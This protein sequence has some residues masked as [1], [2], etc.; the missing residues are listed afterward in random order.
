[1]KSTNEGEAIAHNQGGA[2]AFMLN[3]P[4]SR[5]LPKFAIP[6]VISLVIS[7]LYNIVDQIFVG[8]GIGYLGN[9]A[10][11]II[12]PITVVGWGL[13]LLFGDGGAAFFSISQGAGDTR[14]AGK[15]VGNSVLFSFLTGVALIVIC[16]AAGDSF[17]YALGATD[18]T[19]QFVRD[20]GYIIFAGIPLALAGQTLITI[21]RADGSPKYAMFT[22]LVGCI[23]NI[24][25]D[26]ITIFIWGWGIK[27]A[28]WATIFG[29]AV[30]FIL[31]I[32]YL[33]R[34][35]TFKIKFSDF[36]PDWG[37][38]RQ[39][40]PLGGSSFLT[41]ISIVIVT[42]VNNKLLVSYGAKSEFGADIPLAAFVVIMK[43]FQIVLNIAIGIAA[44]AQPIIG[45]NYGARR[46]DRVKETFKYVITSILAVTLIATALFEMFPKAFIALFGTDSELYT[47]F[48]VH[49]LRIYLS[50][51]ALTCLQK[52]CAIFLQ[53]IGKAKAAIPLSML[54][55]VILLIAFSLVLPVYLGVTGIFWA[56]PA[57]DILA[58]VIT[59]VVI[60]SMWK[61]LGKTETD[62]QIET[63]ILKQSVPGP[64]ITIDREHGSNGKIIGELIAKKLNI[65]FYY[66]EM[67]A[68]AAA[69]SGLSQ[70]FISGINTAEAGK[71]HN[72]YL[73]TEPVRDAIIAQEQALREIAKSGSCVI[74]SRAAGHVLR[75]NNNVVNVFI[76]APEAYRLEQV[77]KTYGDT[78]EQ[79]KKNINRLDSA[80]A[81][82]YAKVSALKWGDAKNY[83][84]CIDSSIGTEK[85]AAVIVEFAK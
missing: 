12:F 23:L 16:Y 49:C 69:E 67:V 84:L 26:P 75:E 56:A 15:A 59:A 38:L 58:M 19:I 18:A 25:F 40:T 65:P 74:V 54:R 72:L 27:G 44:G 78:K 73:D 76:H 14:H 82:Y 3:E 30:S 4:I 34:S 41:Q 47:I 43:L 62:V 21:I 79:G 17:F 83:D 29:Q 42:V 35:K 60:V 11:G 6:C 1:M 5:L 48:A 22:M 24:I 85:A 53:S 9:A 46:F 51:I 80:R 64:I 55:D 13:S 31:A 45:Y 50:L 8:Q 39:V 71:A 28:A 70:D 36:K 63:P 20:Y 10:T 68:L 7:C 81:A 57:A 77:M 66:K 52:A 37:I 33:S 2:S 32:A 61:Q